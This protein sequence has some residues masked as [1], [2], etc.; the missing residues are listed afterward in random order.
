MASAGSP[1][2]PYHYLAYSPDPRTRRYLGVKH[3]PTKNSHEVVLLPSTVT[4][5]SPNEYGPTK[6]RLTS[7]LHAITMN[8]DSDSDNAHD[9]PAFLVVLPRMGKH[10]GRRD[11]HIL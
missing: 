2:V 1:D 6:V 8:N 9:I 4:P 11:H 10:A 5:D 3:D 7:P